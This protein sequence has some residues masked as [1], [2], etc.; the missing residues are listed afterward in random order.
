MLLCNL[1]PIHGLYNGTDLILVRALRHVLECQVL[2]EDNKA[3]VNTVFI[4]CMSLE[5]SK[6]DYSVPL[7]QVQFPVHLA[8]SML[9]SLDAV[10][11]DILRFYLVKGKMIT[12]QQM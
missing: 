10:T 6:E 11:P 9:L 8:Y 7:Q 12:R 3:D 5:A 2:C 1:D 4:P